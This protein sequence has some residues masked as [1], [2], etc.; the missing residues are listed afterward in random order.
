MSLQLNL[1]LHLML[2]NNQSLTFGPSSMSFFLLFIAFF[3]FFFLQTIPL[4]RLAS[5]FSSSFYSLHAHA[6]LSSLPSGFL[7]P[8]TWLCLSIL[9]FT[10]WF[11]PKCFPS[12]GLPIVSK[13]MFSGII[14]NCFFARIYVS[15]IS[16]RSPCSWRVKNCFFCVSVS[17]ILILMKLEMNYSLFQN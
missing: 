2:K 15:H 13:L 17:S 14:V 12:S 1:H 3:F 7:L 10:D 5:L 6:Y 16:T 4:V 9:S 8:S 11:N